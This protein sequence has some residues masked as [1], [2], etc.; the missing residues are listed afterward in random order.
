MWDFF[1]TVT[2]NLKKF[3]TFSLFVVSRLRFELVLWK[4]RLQA[5]LLCQFVCPR[6]GYGRFEGYH[7]RTSLFAAFRVEP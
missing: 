2:L 6:K 3:Y 4:N 7:E 1:G 5:R